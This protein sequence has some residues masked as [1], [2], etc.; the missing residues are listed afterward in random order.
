MTTNT[1]SCCGREATHVRV[2]FIRFLLPVLFDCLFVCLFDCLFVCLFI[3]IRINGH[4]HGLYAQI[5]KCDVTVSP[6]HTSLRGISGPEWF[7]K[8]TV[9]AQKNREEPASEGTNIDSDANGQTVRFLPSAAA[10]A[11]GVEVGSH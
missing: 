3:N 7:M 8:R 11:V 2:S 4:G 10:V 5:M 9:R 6:E 1:A